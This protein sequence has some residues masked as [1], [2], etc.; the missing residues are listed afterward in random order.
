ME[1]FWRPALLAFWSSPTR[2][3]SRSRRR[4]PTPAGGVPAA[5]VGGVRL[6]QPGI[7]G[8][9]VR[10]GEEGAAAGG[11]AIRAIVRIAELGHRAQHR[12]RAAGVATVI[13]DG[14]RD[15]SVM[16]AGG[17]AASVARR[18]HPDVRAFAC[19]PLRRPGRRCAAPGRRGATGDVP[20]REPVSAIPRPGGGGCAPDRARAGP[21]RSGD[22]GIW[23]E[24][25][26]NFVGPSAPGLMSKSKIFVGIQRVAQAFGMST[27]PEMWPWTGAVPRIE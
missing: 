25:S 4:A 6:A 10:R 23:I 2:C 18:T 1:N 19:A 3:S 20:A 5:L 22:R 9:E 11:P 15:L 21:Q 8:G 13:V 14:H 17:S 7:H 16:S 12:E 27:T 24:P 26:R